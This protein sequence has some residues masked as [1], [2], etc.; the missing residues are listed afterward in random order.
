MCAGEKVYCYDFANG[1][2]KLS[3]VKAV[4]KNKYDGELVHL[5]IGAEKIVATAKHP[6]WVIQGEALE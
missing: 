1:A 4:H 5:T 2:W 3:T 6:F